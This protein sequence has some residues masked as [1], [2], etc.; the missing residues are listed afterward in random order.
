MTASLKS[1]FL[2]KDSSSPKYSLLWRILNKWHR[3]IGF[4]SAIWVLAHS[5]P[6]WNMSQN[7]VKSIFKYA[8]NLHSCHDFYRSSYNRFAKI[9]LCWTWMPQKGRTI[10][11]HILTGLRVISIRNVRPIDSSKPWHHIHNPC[12]PA[13]CV[14]IMA[15]SRPVHHL[16][17]VNIPSLCQLS[18]SPILP[19]NFAYPPLKILEYTSLAKFRVNFL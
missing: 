8:A 4:Q 3:G 13:M 11:G 14:Y 12:P 5:R 16:L 18:H 7:F 17:D 10:P 6:G 15:P 19:F 9:L 2:N 1:I